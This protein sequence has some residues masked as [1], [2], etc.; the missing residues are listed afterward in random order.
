M[1][2]Q[3]PWLRLLGCV[4]AGAVLGGLFGAVCGWIAS[5]FANGPDVWQG[6]RESAPWFAMM[7]VVAGFVIGIEK[8]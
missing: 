4:V 3:Q 5:W 1:M 7:G 2:R 8:K 6:I